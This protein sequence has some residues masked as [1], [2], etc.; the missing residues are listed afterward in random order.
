MA[1]MDQMSKSAR[2]VCPQRIISEIEFRGC[3]MKTLRVFWTFFI[4]GGLRVRM[5]YVVKQKNV[6]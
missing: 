4:V 1:T 3:W 6:K 5:Q 2:M